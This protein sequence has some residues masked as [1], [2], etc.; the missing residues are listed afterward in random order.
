MQRG[1]YNPGRTD[2]TVDIWTANAVLNVIADALE[3]IPKFKDLIDGLGIAWDLLTSRTGIL[4]AWIAFEGQIITAIDHIAD[5]LAPLLKGIV[6]VL[7][8]MRQEM[9]NF[10][11]E[12]SLDDIVRAAK[13]V[14]GMLSAPPAPSELV[15]EEPIVVGPP[16][17]AQ[18]DEISK[19]VREQLAKKLK[20]EL[21]PETAFAVYNPTQKSYHVLVS[22]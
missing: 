5:A 9:N 4:T 21:F 6:E 7:T 16:G 8:R 14:L 12:L 10:D 1:E 3:K 19:Q 13:Y 22:A 20:V 2:G 18:P 15:E 17:T 11:V